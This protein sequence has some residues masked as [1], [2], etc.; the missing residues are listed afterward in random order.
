MDF[1]IA[2]FRENDA[3]DFQSFSFFFF[4]LETFGVEVTNKSFLRYYR[5]SAS[6]RQN[7]SNHYFRGGGGGSTIVARKGHDETL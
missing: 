4:S 5:K 6:I 7:Q 3:E 2:R 1:G